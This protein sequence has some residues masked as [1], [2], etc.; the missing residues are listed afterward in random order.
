MS[1]GQCQGYRDFCTAA[2]GHNGM[3][4][5]DW[6]FTR[7]NRL[8]MSCT[9]LTFSLFRS[10]SL[11][12]PL[13]RVSLFAMNESNVR[14]IAQVTIQ[15]KSAYW[16]SVPVFCKCREIQIKNAS[17]T[18]AARSIRIIGPCTVPSSTTHNTSTTPPTKQGTSVQ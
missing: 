3:L 11:V 15:S 2:A 13:F 6:N 4:V 7:N 10:V 1:V 8:A 14:V 16:S 17:K 12:P 5:A 9:S 18:N